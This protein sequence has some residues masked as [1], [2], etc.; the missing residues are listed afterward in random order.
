MG[1]GFTRIEPPTSIASGSVAFRSGSSY[2][3][4]PEIG[5]ATV[6]TPSTANLTAA[7]AATMTSAIKPSMRAHSTEVPPAWQGGRCCAPCR[8]LVLQL[9]LTDHVVPRVFPSHRTYLAN[10]PA[11][12]GPR[13]MMNKT[14]KMKSTRGTMILTGT[15]CAFSSAT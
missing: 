12:A 5:H 7:A 14:G 13:M 4:G 6:K 2:R 8:Q 10:Q 1:C 3:Q 11:A 9:I 15:F